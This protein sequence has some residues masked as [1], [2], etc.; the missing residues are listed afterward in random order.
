MVKNKAFGFVTP[1][2]YEY[3]AQ[4]YED[5][6]NLCDLVYND[7]ST[8]ENLKAALPNKPE[9]KVLQAAITKRS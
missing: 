3:N 8:E 6:V 5:L 2:H 1:C 9:F 7:V 4:E